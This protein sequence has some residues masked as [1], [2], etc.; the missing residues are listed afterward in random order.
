MRC[1][2]LCRLSH[3][4]SSWISVVLCR[5]PAAPRRSP[6]GE[7]GHR[8]VVSG[9]AMRS[10]AGRRRRRAQEEPRNAQR[11]RVQ[12]RAAGG[13]SAA[14]PNSRPRRCL[15][16]RSSRCLRRRPSWCARSCAM[17]T[18]PEAGSEALDL[19]F[20]GLRR[21]SGVTR[22]DMCIGVDGVDVSARTLRVRQV[23]L[24]QQDERALRHV[25]PVDRGLRGGDLVEA[26][27]QVE[28]ARPTRGFVC[29]RES[30]PRRRNSRRRHRDRAGIG[31]V[32]R[33]TR[34]GSASPA[35]RTAAAGLVSSMTMS[36]S[37][38]SASAST[39]DPRLHRSAGTLQ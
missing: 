15:R 32:P 34:P 39:R 13:R 30:R 9:H 29:P 14:S 4:H 38:R 20:D 28:G 8:C 23:L 31:P 5:H 6:L 1:T 11:V 26:P 2:A 37:G 16:P 19:V 22:R 12:R 33:A 7:R 27:A 21:V 3:I 25:P 10:R 36:A 24:A 35:I 18:V 17:I